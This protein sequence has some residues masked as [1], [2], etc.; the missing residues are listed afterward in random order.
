[1]GSC[2]GPCIG[3]VSVEG[4]TRVQVERATA[5][6]P[7]KGWSISFN[8]LARTRWPNAP[9]G[10]NTS[11]PTQASNQIAAIAGLSERQHVARPRET[12]EDV[13]GYTVSGDTVYLMVFSVEKGLLLGKQE[14]SFDTGKIFSTNSWSGPMRTVFPPQNLSSLMKWTRPWPRTYRN[15]KAGPSI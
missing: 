11:M 6:L 14:Y 5:L 12:D 4:D 15:G 7:G 13:I 3:A 8:T 10:W 9:V 1:M 2:S